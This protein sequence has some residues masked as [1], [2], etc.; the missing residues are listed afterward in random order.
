MNEGPVYVAVLMVHEQPFATKE[1][2]EAVAAQWDADHPEELAAVASL[3]AE[4]LDHVAD[5]KATRVEEWPADKWDRQ[6]PG[7]RKAVWSRM[8]DRRIVHQ[9]L[10]AYS[11]DGSISH[12]FQSAAPVWEF[13]TDS[14]TTKDAEW[15]V[16]RRPGPDGLTEAWVRGCS[17]EAVAEA[18][19]R[20]RQ[21][22]LRVCGVGQ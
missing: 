9:A 11:P 4:G 2:A 19:V 1:L 20:A 7:G 15:R 3:R 6:G 8:P 13:Q 12:E 17:E 10:M 18:Y 16:E 21:E 22:A 5:R 14:Y